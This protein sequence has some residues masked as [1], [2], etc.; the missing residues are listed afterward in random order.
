MVDLDRPA[1]GAA[2]GFGGSGVGLARLGVRGGRN[3][4]ETN[5]VDADAGRFVADPGLGRKRPARTAH[6]HSPY[7]GTRPTLSFQ[8][9][10][11]PDIPAAVHAEFDLGRGPARHHERPPG[12]SGDGRART[13]Q[14]QGD[15]RSDRGLGGA[16]RRAKRTMR[17]D[18]G[19]SPD[20]RGGAGESDRRCLMALSPIARAHFRLSESSADTSAMPGAGPAPRLT[21]HGNHHSLALPTAQL[22]R[23]IKLPRL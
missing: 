19:L 13:W 16:I 11:R 14:R 8:S 1:H 22:P 3:R 7:P 4:S 21:R 17:G 5:G 15:R 9:S 10:T 18:L 2:P 6:A 12:R 20:H 23:A